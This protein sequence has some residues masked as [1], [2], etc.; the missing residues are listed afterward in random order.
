M[1]ASSIL[2]SL[3]LLTS[4]LAPRA[5]ANSSITVNFD[6]NAT[7]KLPEGWKAEGTNQK[8]PVATWQVMADPT[9]PSGPNVLA[10][11]KINHDSGDT[12][13]ICWSDRITFKDGQIEVRFKAISGEEDQGGGVIWRARDK[14]NYYIARYNPLEE[15]YRVYFVKDGARKQLATQKIAIPAGEWHTMK[16][17]HKGDHIEC[18][19][20]GKKHLDVHDATFASEGGVGLWTKADAVTSFDDLKVTPASDD[21]HVD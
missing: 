16:I 9:A 17:E 3:I 6:K 19:L 14:N 5:P 7:G 1:H 20:D 10:L 21:D 18:S 11:S 2:I 13:N 8:G 4:T 15:N 12:Y